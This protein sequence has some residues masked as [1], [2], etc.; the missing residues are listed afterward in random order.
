MASF[1]IN[2]E[3]PEFEYH[4]KTVSWYWLSIIIAAAIIAFSIWERNFLFGIFIVIAE[5][6]LI[7]WGNEKPRIIGFSITE[8]TLTIDGAKNYQMKLFESFSVDEQGENWAEL[9]FTFKAK[10]KTPLKIIMPKAKLEEARKNIKTILREVE[11]EPSLLDSLEK[12][13]GF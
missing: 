2:W 12:I 11:F 10:L 7:A 1:E 13:I 8:N 3:A 6:L 5:I 4:P 9:F